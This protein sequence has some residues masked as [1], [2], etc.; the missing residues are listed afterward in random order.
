MDTNDMTSDHEVTGEQV[1]AEASAD[2]VTI[3]RAEIQAL[4]ESA[5]REVE[6]REQASRD[7]AKVAELERQAGDWRSAYRAAVRDRELATALVGRPL[8]PG[9]A[10]QLL[11]LWRDEFDVV[12]E[13][14]RA[15]VV[16]RDGL[17]VDRAVTEW[18]GSPDFAHFRPPS[19]RGGTASHGES[20]TTAPAVA[21]PRTLGES[22]LQEWR[23]SARGASESSAPIGLGRRR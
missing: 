4:R 19:S 7:S 10:A 20:R 17:P 6:W 21:P 15:R 3:P 12:E 16:S 18:L 9:A 22:V 14:G 23:A 13:D 1:G 5:T 2:F 11:K 8:V